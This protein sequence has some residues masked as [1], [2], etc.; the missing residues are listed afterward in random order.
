MLPWSCHE[1]RFEYRNMGVEKKSKTIFLFSDVG[2]K[3]E[4][5]SNYQSYFLDKMKAIQE[6]GN[7]VIPRQVNVF[8]DY[9][10]SRSFRRGSTTVA[11]NA[12][13]EVCSEED[14]IRNNHR[15]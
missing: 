7:G 1:D 10:I 6:Q 12:P 9:G 5:G 13:N 15:R 11:L 3:K 14:I 2:G 4:T 8:D